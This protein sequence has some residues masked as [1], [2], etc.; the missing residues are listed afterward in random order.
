VS[1]TV[2]LEYLAPPVTVRGYHQKL[3]FPLLAAKPGFLPLPLAPVFAVFEDPEYNRALISQTSHSEGIFVDTLATPHRILLSLDRREYNPNSRFY[4]VYVDQSPVKL[5]TA[6]LRIQAIPQDGVPR[7]L[8]TIP[9][10][11]ATLT[12]QDVTSLYAGA[13][14]QPVAGDSISCTLRAGLQDVVTVRVDIVAEPVTPAP[15]AAYGLLRKSGN[16]VECVRFAWSA[17][18]T[19]I[20]LVNPD[21]LLGETVRRRAVFDWLD[22]N[23]AG[24]SSQYGVQKVAAGGSTHSIEDTLWVTPK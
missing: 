21:D 24:R 11:N 12:E 7:D 3:V 10:T 16:A 8:G 15:Q 20:E 6:S 18:A 9:V 22:T 1:V 4:V 13:G 23:R 2:G 14:M 17:V 19:N 5:A